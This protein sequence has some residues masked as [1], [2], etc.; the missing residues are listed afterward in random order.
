MEWNDGCSTMRVWTASAQLLAQL[1][2]DDPAIPLDP[3]LFVASQALTPGFGD[4]WGDLTSA[5]AGESYRTRVRGIVRQLER[6]LTREI[7]YAERLIA[8][9]RPIREVLRNVDARLSSLGCYLVAA[10][11]GRLDLAV[12]F[13]AGVFLQHRSCPLYRS[14]CLAFLPADHYPVADSPPRDEYK[15]PPVVRAMIASLN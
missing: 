13:E 6:E 9:G 7:R 12:E 1:H 4:A 2:G 10:R 14:A 11:A 8:K 15:A 3:E 5:A